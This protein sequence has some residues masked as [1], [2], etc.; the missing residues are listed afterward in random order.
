MLQACN[1]RLMV[2]TQKVAQ[3]ECTVGIK[4][5]GQNL[6]SM[7]VNTVPKNKRCL[8]NY[9]LYQHLS[10]N[11]IKSLTQDFSFIRKP[12]SILHSIYSLNIFALCS[13]ERYYFATLLK[14]IWTWS[15][16]CLFI[17]HYIW[18]GI[19]DLWL[20]KASLTHKISK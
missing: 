7:R 10:D 2:H 16:M 15:T 12:N 3:L 4:F 9:W 6:N 14:K 20:T 17:L 5:I 19:F 8:N 18:N 1:P 11:S 13:Y